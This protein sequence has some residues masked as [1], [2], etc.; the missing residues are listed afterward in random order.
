MISVLTTTFDFYSSLFGLEMARF[1][2]LSFLVLVTHFFRLP[3]KYCETITI[4][5][6]VPGSYC[7]VSYY[8]ALSD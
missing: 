4:P 5:V 1:L 2:R 3:A 7:H 6:R 8:K